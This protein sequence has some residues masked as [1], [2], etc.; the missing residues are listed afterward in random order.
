MVPPAQS[1]RPPLSKVDPRR[2]RSSAS[3]TSRVV[4]CCHCAL[5]RAGLRQ[6]LKIRFTPAHAP[7]NRAA[8]SPTESQRGY[9]C[10]GSS[11]DAIQ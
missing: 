4:G 6:D 11:N 8:S 7:H 1:V 9:C 3:A 5:Q 2:V 10:S